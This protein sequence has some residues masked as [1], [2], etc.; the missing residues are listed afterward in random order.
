MFKRIA[1]SAF[2]ILMGALLVV[3]A[4][5]GTRTAF[6]SAKSQQPVLAAGEMD[7]GDFDFDEDYD[8]C[9]CPDWFVIA[10]EALGMDEDPLW[11]AFEGGQTIA[12]L[13]AEKG[14]D[15]QTIIAAVVAAE[16]AFTTE[17]VTVGEF[18][19]EEADEWLSELPDEAQSFLD[20][21]IADWELWEGVDWFGTAATTLGLDEDALFENIEA[22]QTIA[23]IAAAQGV[24]VEDISN[25]ILAAET[26][27][28]D[29]MVAAG[30]FTQEDADEWLAEIP[31][32]T[33]YFLEEALDEWEDWDDEDE[34]GLDWYAVTAETLGVDEDALF[35]ALDSGQSIAEFAQAQDAD[36]QAV[37]DAIVAAEK[38]WV[39]EWLTELP[40]E[41]QSFV[42][43]SWGMDFDEEMP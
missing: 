40:T 1:I 22:G 36:P 28:L 30:E 8:D 10:A 35:E 26:A 42:E 34:Y 4:I 27:W 5:Y 11:E 39:A 38:D 19:Q 3:G 41:A 6:A 12:Q 43:E 33:Q 24:V 23:E 16:T 17:M 18:T 21:S 14:V 9:D 37:I 20:E 31:E 29:E 13:A 25:A 32:E 7:D 2:G 15:P